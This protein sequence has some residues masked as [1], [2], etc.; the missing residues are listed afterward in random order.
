M[1]ESNTFVQIPNGI[2]SKDVVTMDLARPAQFL[3]FLFGWQS[4]SFLSLSRSGTFS[5]G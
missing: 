2:A 4:L 5:I 3:R 1:P